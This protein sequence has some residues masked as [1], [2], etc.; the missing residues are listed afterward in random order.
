LQRIVSI[1]PADKKGETIKQQRRAEKRLG[2]SR[3]AHSL[4]KKQPI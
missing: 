1:S 3:I 2:A 4:D